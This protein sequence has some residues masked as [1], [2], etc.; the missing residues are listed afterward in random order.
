MWRPASGRSLPMEKRTAIAAS[1]CVDVKTSERGD[2]VKR[3]SERIQREMHSISYQQYRYH[4][5]N[6]T[7]SGSGAANLVRVEEVQGPKS[8]RTIALYDRDHMATTR[9]SSHTVSSL[10][11][12]D[13][14][15]TERQMEDSTGELKLAP[16]IN[17]LSRLGSWSR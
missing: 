9:V 14:N 7:T 10:S 4:G 16:T 8:T 13:S 1:A 15:F 3:A 12:A 17:G 2:A 5:S 6:C 11:S